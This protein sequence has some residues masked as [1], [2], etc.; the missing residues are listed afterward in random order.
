MLEDCKS[1]LGLCGCLSALS[2][3]ASFEELANFLIDQIDV[4]VETTPRTAIALSSYSSKDTPAALRPAPRLTGKAADY[5]DVFE[6]RLTVE[7][8]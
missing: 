7:L 4:N 1:E 6:G 5:F 8:P 2:F 3:G